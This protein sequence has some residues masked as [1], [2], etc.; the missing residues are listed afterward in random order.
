MK[1]NHPH[2]IADVFLTF[3]STWIQRL[4]VFIEWVKISKNCRTLHWVTSMTLYKVNYYRSN[5]QLYLQIRSPSISWAIND[6]WKH[7]SESPILIESDQIDIFVK[8]IVLVIVRNSVSYQINLMYA[9]NELSSRSYRC[10]ICA[11]L[12]LAQTAKIQVRSFET[13]GFEIW[14]VSV[15]PE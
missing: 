2:F 10:T 4:H 15:L 5:N 1:R 7:N 12:S 8:R 3:W 11:H 6:D 13:S 9:T 14:V